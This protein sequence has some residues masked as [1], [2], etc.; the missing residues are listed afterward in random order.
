VKISIRIGSV[1]RFKVE[2]EKGKE[3]RGEGELW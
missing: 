2:C 1:N 3:R